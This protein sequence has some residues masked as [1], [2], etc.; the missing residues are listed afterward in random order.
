VKD[1]QAV[2]PALQCVPRK[3]HDQGAGEWKVQEEG[4][5]GRKNRP[6]TPV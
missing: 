3:R 4:D 1:V 5:R 2:R 6:G